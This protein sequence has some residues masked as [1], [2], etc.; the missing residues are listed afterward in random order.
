MIDGHAASP[1]WE[2]PGI[3]LRHMTAD[4][5]AAGMRLVG[6]AGWNQTEEDW[7]LFLGLSP[8][9]C[10]VAVADGQVI[11]TVTTLDYEGRV[12][13][14]S[15]LLVDPAFRHMGIGSRLFDRAL[16][17]VSGCGTIALDATP[18]GQGLYARR[19]FEPLFEI[20]R[21][22]IDRLP[23]L[24]DLPD[25]VGPIA[26][27]DWPAIAAL[28]R[29]VFGADRTPL[30]R[31]LWEGAPQLAWRRTREERPVGFCFGRRGTR[32][33]QVGPIVAETN[34]D[35]VALCG[36]CMRG[37]AGRA[38]VLDVPTFQ[39]A[40]RTWL[41]HL[42]FSHQRSLTRMILSPEQADAALGPQSEHQF[43]I[44][45]PELG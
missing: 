21:L 16:D 1:M 28:D 8:D 3:A 42:G 40:L 20:D 13:W 31:A 38:I 4:D 35:A 33:V 22:V 23:P 34:E 26:G 5:I 7:Q 19:G 18:A 36:A 32:Y 14:I 45:G 37:L 17:A 2:A 27:E 11:G 12:A 30:L 29:P 43:A 6:E 25:G 15:M 39:P 24:G 44:A 10:F 9:R 41:E